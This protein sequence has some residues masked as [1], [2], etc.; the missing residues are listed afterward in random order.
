MGILTSA[1]RTTT[2][3]ASATTSAA[4]AVAGASVGGALGA[5]RGAVHGATIG[6]G[7]GSQSRPAAA[8]GLAALGVSGLVDWP[9]V[10]IGGGAAL[11]LD[12]VAKGRRSVR[13]IPQAGNAVSTVPALTSAEVAQP[14]RPASSRRRSAEVAMDEPPGVPEGV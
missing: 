8:L 7:E 5:V 3:L 11:I 12:S 2:G 10:L 13:R 9:V 14:R 1:A 6:I 4:G